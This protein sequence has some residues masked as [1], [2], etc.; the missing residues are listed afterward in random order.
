M[1]PGNSQGPYIW[2]NATLAQNFNDYLPQ[3]PEIINPLNQAAFLIERRHGIGFDVF[4][5][6]DFH[7]Q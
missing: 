6:L 2:C 4:V 7:R 3:S 1:K 5:E